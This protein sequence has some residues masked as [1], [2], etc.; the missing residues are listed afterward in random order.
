M[1][2]DFFWGVA[3]AAFQTEGE[4]G[5]SDWSAW[6]R[7]PGR[8]ADGSTGAG[9]FGFYRRYEREF[10]TARELGAN[11]FRMSLAWE[12]IEPSRG[13]FDESA[14]AHYETM[15]VAMRA[16]GIEP[17][18]TLHHFVTP[19]W[20]E[21]GVLHPDFSERFAV[22][23]EKAIA[24][25]SRA[26]ARVR[27]WT[28]LNEPVIAAVAGYL[29][30]QF[31][32]GRKE[33]F[34]GASQTMA[35]FIRAHV[36]AVNRAR[37]LPEGPELHLGI[38]KHWR[39]FEPLRAW[40]PID[41]IIARFSESFFNRQLTRGILTG[42]IDIFVPGGKRIREKIAIEGGKSG[43]DYFG[44]NYYGRTRVG[45]TF[46]PPF[47]K[48]A[49]GPG[50]KNDLDWEMYPEGLYR[51][52]KQVSRYGLPIIITENGLADADDSRR[53]EFIRDHVA[54]LDRARAAGVDVI[55]YLH[56]TL[57][58]NFEWAHGFGPKFGL[59][60]AEG[61]GSERCR[62]SFAVYSRIIKSHTT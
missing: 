14:L 41:Q 5:E 28:T 1:K 57:T 56:W 19:A 11:A 44:V 55:G 34:T 35:Q 38:A 37:A 16:R 7:E 10:D 58:D 39:P 15:I 43:A 6:T 12:R 25:L 52:L 62:P 45:F 40:S 30:G 33:D 36:K 20:L 61:S 50:P 54:Q 3:N 46:R 47:V 60:A 31:P 21:G 29:D 22:F 9:A 51:T 53:G 48:V 13:A 23:A 49:E 18:V 8:I 27:W 2:P 26:P 32:P 42:E 24:R 4:P 59:C 17:F